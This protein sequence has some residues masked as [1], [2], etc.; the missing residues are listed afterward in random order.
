MS[1]GKLEDARGL[2]QEALRYLPWIHN[3]NPQQP[4]T[5]VS[6]I[7]RCEPGTRSSPKGREPPLIASLGSY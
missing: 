3:E 1:A 5:G 6:E 7:G 4:C 2:G